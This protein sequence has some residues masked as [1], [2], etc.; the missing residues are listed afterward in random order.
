M[1]LCSAV[2]LLVPA[3]FARAADEF[4]AEFQGEAWDEF[5]LWTRVRALSKAPKEFG[6]TFDQFFVFFFV[7]TQP[8]TSQTGGRVKTLGVS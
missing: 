1:R 8:T 5:F 3:L 2:G 7:R 6:S 4:G